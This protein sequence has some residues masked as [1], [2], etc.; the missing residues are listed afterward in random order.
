MRGQRQQP[1][2]RDEQR[3]V[4][5]RPGQRSIQCDHLP[6]GITRAGVEIHPGTTSRQIHVAG[7]RTRLHH[8][9]YQQVRPQ[10]EVK[11]LRAAARIVGEVRYQWPDDRCARACRVRQQGVQV[12][13]QAIA[14]AD[15]IP[16]QRQHFGVHPGFGSQPRQPDR[17]NGEAWLENGLLHPAQQQLRTGRFAHKT[18]HVMP[19]V[20]Q[21]GQAEAQPHRC[22]VAQR[23]P[24]RYIVAGPRLRVTLHARRARPGEHVRPL[25]G[26]GRFCRLIGRLAHQH[27]LGRPRQPDRQRF[28]EPRAARRRIPNLELVVVV[29]G[30]FDAV[31]K[32]GFCQA[33]LPPGVGHRIGKVQVGRSLGLRDAAAPVG[34]HL[35]PV[36]VSRTDECPQRGHFFILRMGAQQVRL[37]VGRKPDARRR[38]TGHHRRRVGDFVRVPGEHLAPP[39]FVRGVTGRKVE[40]LAGDGMLLAQLDEGRQLRVSV[41]QFRVEHRGAK[42]TQGPARRQVWQP[43]QAREFAHHVQNA[44]PVDQRIVHVAIDG[45]IV[46]VWP[47]NGVD[48]APQVKDTLR[49]VVIEQPVSH[50]QVRHVGDVERPV[51]VKRVAACRVI[52]KRISRVQ[53]DTHPGLV[54]RPGDLAKAVVMLIQAARQQ[55]AHQLT[56]PVITIGAVHAILDEGLARRV[57]PLNLHGCQIDIQRELP[58]AQGQRPGMPFQRRRRAGERT[59]VVAAAPLAGHRAIGTDH[60]PGACQARRT[61]RHKPHAHKVRLQHADRQRLPA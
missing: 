6:A 40:H 7:R 11:G 2:R 34:H 27:R 19:A 57:E 52:S 3:N 46:A 33:R 31:L 10:H 56:G 43:D 4:T 60:R 29:P 45:F 1:A 23:G 47:V 42:I 48:L 30:H 58:G 35:R 24:R 20:G 50:I 5:L 36:L 16:H 18:A 13:D 9:G 21:P 59:Q 37:D 17:V 15:R 39:A 53:P 61:I 38:E 32:H 55:V 22:V 51:F 41:R 54:Q 8:R 44:R 25:A 28:P 12:R 26:A 49:R 14:E